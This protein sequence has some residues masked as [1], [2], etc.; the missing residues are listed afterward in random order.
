MADQG[1]T[2]RGNTYIKSDVSIMC[3][4]ITSHHGINPFYF[5]ERPTTEVQHHQKRQPESNRN[6]KVILFVLPSIRNMASIEMRQ[7]FYRWFYAPIFYFSSLFHINLSSSYKGFSSRIVKMVSTD[8]RQ[9]IAPYTHSDGCL[10]NGRNR[11]SLI[12]AVCGIDISRHLSDQ[13]PT[14]IVWV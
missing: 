10:G 13:K 14:Y 6:H 8:A 7:L 5:R 9:G 1:V 12:S 11:E 2:I 4:V 3:P